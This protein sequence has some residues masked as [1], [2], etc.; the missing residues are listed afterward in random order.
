MGEHIGQQGLRRY[1]DRPETVR[2]TDTGSD[3]LT[4]VGDRGHYKC[5]GIGGKLTLDNLV[6][7]SEVGDWKMPD[8]KAACTY[9]ASQGWHA[10]HSRAG[11]GLTAI[12]T[13]PCI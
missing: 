12:G 4:A 8:F 11:G 13:K 7:T 2:P 10:D 6:A 1:L 3:G 9:A 5:C